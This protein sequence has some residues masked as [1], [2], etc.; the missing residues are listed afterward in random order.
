MTVRALENGIVTF[1]RMRS[2][3]SVLVVIRSHLFQIAVVAVAAS[4]VPPLHAAQD[5]P[6]WLIG[7]EF[8][9]KLD[10]P[11]GVL[12]ADIP[13]RAA[14]NDFAHA[15]RVAI[16]LD[17]R[18]DP[19][20]K[21][22]LAV[23]NEP[24]LTIIQTVAA[25]LDLGASIFGNVVYL[26][27]ASS[28]R[29]IRTVAEARK[30]EIAAIDAAASK[31]SR[32]APMKWPD[33]QTPRDLLGELASQ[34]GLE[35]VNLERVPHD[36]WAA[37]DFPLMSLTERM[38]SILQQFGLTFRVA[39][40]GRRVALVELSSE[41][42]IV[43]DYPGGSSPERLVDAWRAKLPHC[44]FRIARNRIYVR[45]RIEDH[46]MLDQLR[47]PGGSRAE[48]QRPTKSGGPAP[49]QVF[50]VQVPDR[51]L[52]AVLTQLADQLGVQLS[53]DQASLDRAG[54]SLDQRI[55]FRVEGATFDELFD[56]ALAPVGCAHRREG[57]ILK[58][59]AQP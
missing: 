9:E 1:Q 13:L 23:Q 37:G 26:G 57:N 58:V 27:P 12:W 34:S 38:T 29:Q 54:I 3:I 11:S 39:E 21:L 24:V 32:A 42:A 7:E 40:D 31:F 50:T 33:L 16:L 41:V 43:R 52:G 8:H 18:V 28:A 5:A 22:E 4:S 20:Q 48:R 44:E 45:G 25:E 14:I 55:S 36:L 6:D 53:V 30:Q 17:R 51:P 47:R 46:E 15:Q 10:S 49:Q 35:I 59:W 19:D 56:A 2:K